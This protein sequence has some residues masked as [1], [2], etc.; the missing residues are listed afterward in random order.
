MIPPGAA[1]GRLSPRGG[2]P[3][4]S[5]RLRAREWLANAVRP[6]R[7]TATPAARQSRFRGVHWGDRAFVAAILLLAAAGARACD[8]LLTEHRSGRELLRAPIDA[9]TLRIAF[10]HSVLGTPVE[11]RYVW[12]DGAWRLVEERFEGQGYGLP[13]A[14]VDGERLERDGP[15]WRLVLDRTVQPLLLRAPAAAQMRLVLGDGRAWSLTGL[16]REAIEVRALAC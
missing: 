5:E 14:A 12:R 4:P 16:S 13:H 11:D 9:A 7:R 2:E 6:T 10:T 1:F 3:A 15:A 8:L